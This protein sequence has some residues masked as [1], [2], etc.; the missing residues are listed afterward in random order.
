MAANSRTS[1]SRPK[2][3]EYGRHV[4]VEETVTEYAGHF[5]KDSRDKTR[6]E[7]AAEIAETYYQLVTDFYEHGWGQSFHFA[8]VAGDKTKEECIVEYERDVART[9]KAKP[10]MKILVSCTSVHAL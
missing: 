5:K 8:P 6:A 1:Y 7:N 2:L 9:L 3:T 10:G 4:Q